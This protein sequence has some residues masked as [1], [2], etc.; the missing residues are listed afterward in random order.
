MQ[1]NRHRTAR[2]I[3]QNWGLYLLLLPSYAVIE[4]LAGPD[5]QRYQQGDLNG[6]YSV[7]SNQLSIT[8]ACKYP[9]VVL[10]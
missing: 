2:R 7:K 10:R 9:E 6:L 5:G 1:Q 3:A 4:P 8:A